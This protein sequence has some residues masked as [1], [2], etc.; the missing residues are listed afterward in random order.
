MSKEEYASQPALGMPRPTRIAL[1]VL[2]SLSLS[3]LIVILVK[4]QKR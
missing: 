1:I 2:S 4:M 3:A